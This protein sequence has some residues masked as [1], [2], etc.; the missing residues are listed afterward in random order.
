MAGTQ[1]TWKAG[2]WAYNSDE[3]VFYLKV[4]KSSGSRG[5]KAQE[6][7]DQPF[8]KALL[9]SKL[10]RVRLVISK[11]LAEVG[12]ISGEQTGLGK[13]SRRPSPV[14]TERPSA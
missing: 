5:D 1:Y 7:V 13:A 11:E 4:Y 2:T 3:R 12:M 14:N 8:T 6:V 10:K 9:A